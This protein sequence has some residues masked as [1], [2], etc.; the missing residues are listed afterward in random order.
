MPHVFLLPELGSVEPGGVHP[1]PPEEAVHAARVLRLRAGAAVRLID[2]RGLRADAEVVAA[3][4][5]AVRVRVGE[6]ERPDPP[7]PRVRLLAAP[8]KGERAEAMVDQLA[9]LGVASWT[10]LLTERGGGDGSPNRRRRW[11]RAAA[12]A[13]KQCGRADFLSVEPAASAAETVQRIPPDA[14]RLLVVADPAGRRPLLPAGVEEVVA[15]VGP[16]GGFTDAEREELLAAGAVPWG[17]G[18]HVLRI[19]TAAVAVAAVVRALIP[20]A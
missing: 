9:Q 1:L 17:L 4:R 2:G 12:E 6:R 15:L 16:E 7:R 3:E 14:G 5:G 18:P 20:E 8:P 13:A 19:E 10:P 11:G